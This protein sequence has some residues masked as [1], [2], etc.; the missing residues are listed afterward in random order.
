R[1]VDDGLRSRNFSRPR[2]GLAIGIPRHRP[3]ASRDVL[4]ARGS[5]AEDHDLVS[6]LRERGRQRAAEKTSA[7]G[8]HNLHACFSPAAA[9]EIPARKGRADGRA[10]AG[11]AGWAGWAAHQKIE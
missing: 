9:S 2:S 3:R 5:A 8:N 7:A 6:L 1:E 11:W 10:R 4:R